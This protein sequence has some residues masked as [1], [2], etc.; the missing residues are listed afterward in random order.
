MTAVLFVCT[1][2]AGR[3]QMAEALFNKYAKSR[4]RAISAGIVPGKQV[5]PL[6]MEVLKEIGIDISGNKPKLVTN[7][8][9]KEADKI[10]T[11]GCET[12]FCPANFLPKVEDW[13]LED[14]KGKSIEEIREIRDKIDRKVKAL[15]QKL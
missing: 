8:M 3:S 2:N 14:P 15:I 13:A 5:N 10:I 6:V 4:F 11:M 7:E 1:E 12:D 9:I